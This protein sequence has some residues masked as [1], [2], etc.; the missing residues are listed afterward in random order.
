MI[1]EYNQK[2]SKTLSQQV[3]DWFFDRN[4]TAYQTAV[5]QKTVFVIPDVIQSLPELPLNAMVSRC[6][7]TH[8]EYALVSRKY[9]SEDHEIRI[10]DLVIGG[11]QE[12]VKIIGPCSVESR[13]QIFESAAIVASNG[14]HILRGGV[15]KPRTSPYSFQGL[16]IE[17]LKLLKEA[18]DTYQLKTAT[19]VMNESDVSVVAEYCDILQIGTRNMQNFGLL[20]AVGK[21]QKPVIL[22]RGFSATIQEWLNAAEYIAKQGNRNIILMERGIRTFEKATRNTLDLSVIPLLKQLTYLPVCFDP[23]HGTGIRELVGP[24][25]LAGLSAGADGVMI[26]MHPHPD[27]ALSD[28]MQSLTPTQWKQL[29]QHIDQLQRVLNNIYDDS[30][31]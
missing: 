28:G 17:G 29:N 30:K 18:A 1:L 6:I 13:L 11:S 19:E 24:M 22:K 2:L 23:S 31:G 7:L 27:E 8:P 21:T 5:D 20:E 12:A 4:Y 3:V 9:Q 16:G 25:T 14:G 10:G 26:E 15:F